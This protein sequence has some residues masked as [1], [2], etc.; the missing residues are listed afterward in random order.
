SPNLFVSP[1]HL[2]VIFFLGANLKVVCTENLSEAECVAKLEE[3][4]A[5][6]R[7]VSATCVERDKPPTSWHGRIRSEDPQKPDTY[8]PVI[9][10]FTPPC[11]QNGRPLKGA[12]GGIFADEDP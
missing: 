5:T 11:W 9:C 7:H 4:V 12:L 2:I 8:Y 6:R 3:V 10:P 1:H